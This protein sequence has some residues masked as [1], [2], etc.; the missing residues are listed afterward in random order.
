VEYTYEIRQSQQVLSHE[1][2]DTSLVFQI[3]Y[4]LVWITRYFC[5]TEDKGPCTD[6]NS[7]IY[8][9]SQVSKFP[10]WASSL[11]VLYLWIPTGIRIILTEESTEFN[12]NNIHHCTR[13]RVYAFGAH[14]PRAQNAFFHSYMA[15]ERS[16]WFLD[17]QSYSQS[18]ARVENQ[19]FLTLVDLWLSQLW[20]VLSSGM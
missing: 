1:N 17:L 2:A 8:W 5:H 9:L 11:W 18:I 16:G 3:P 19:Q 14:L 15:S 6:R 12:S 13:L 4:W 7:E 20:R 10:Y